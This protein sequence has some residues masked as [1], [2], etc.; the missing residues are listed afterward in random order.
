MTRK[1]ANRIRGA[2]TGVKR[3]MYGVKI[4]EYF[5][6]AISKLLRPN[7]NISSAAPKQK[8][9]WCA[10][11]TDRRGRK[12]YIHRYTIKECAEPEIYYTRDQ[13]EAH[14]FDDHDEALRFTKFVGAHTEK[15]LGVIY[16]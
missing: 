3:N 8:T 7:M 13:Q 16:A 11:Q 6:N 10:Y 12:K 14:R 1:D 4:G 15:V 5:E 2:L 9:E